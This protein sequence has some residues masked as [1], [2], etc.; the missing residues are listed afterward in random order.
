MYW[1]PIQNELP[2]PL[3]Y[4]DPG[5]AIEHYVTR[6]YTALHLAAKEGHDEVAAMLLDHGAFVDSLSRFICGCWPLRSF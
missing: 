3:E 6:E 4:L 5:E 2:A 1:S